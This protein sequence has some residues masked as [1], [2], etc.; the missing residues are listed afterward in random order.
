MDFFDLI[1]QPSAERA[2]ELEAK[3]KKARHD[4][5][6]GT[7]TVSDDVYDAWVA[8]L[9]EVKPD[10]DAVTAVGATPVSEWE[11]VEHS[12][13][14]GS[15]DNV[16]T[17]DELTSWLSGTGE[18]QTAPLM[19]SEKLDGISIAVDYVKGELDKAATRGD[20]N[21]GEDITVNVSKME[22]VRGKLP[23]SFT[24][25][26]RGEIILKRSYHAKYFPEKANPRNAASGIA[27]RYDGQG[28]EH[29]SVK[30]YQV[31]DGQDF[32][33]EA[34]QFKW[35]EDH[36]FDT[37]NWYVT[38]M[39]PGVRTPQDLWLEYQQFKRDELDYDIDGLVVRINNMAAQLALGEKDNCPRGAVAF[40]FAATTRESVLQRIEWQVGGT[41]R[42]TP[43]AIFRPVNI[44]GAEITNAS[45]Y[46]VAYIRSLGLD[47]GATIIVSRAQDVIPRVTEVVKGVGT[48]ANPPSECPACGTL[49][50]AAGEYLICPNA[51]GCPA[52]SVGRI[53]RY[54]AAMDI[55]EWGETLI[56]K[57][58]SSGL[59]KDVSDLYR[60]TDMQLTNVERMGKKSAAKVIKTL[61]VK[62]KVPLE[63][64]LGSLSIPLCASSTIKMA[65]DAGYDT[66]DKLKAASM[67]QLSGVEGLGPVKAQALHTWLQEESEVVDRLLSLG[68]E[69]EAKIQG[70]LTG[71]SF[72]FTGALSKPRPT[73]EKMV[74]DAGGEVKKSVGKRLS[75]LVMADPN[76]NTSKAQ[77]ARKNNTKC[78]SEAEFL[79]ILEG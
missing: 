9:A 26:L 52:Q 56:E 27:R 16:K 23:R 24:G 47:V 37:P 11:K 75:Y 79:A 67:S 18:S 31:A 8:E 35:L 32:E 36:G 21:I 17:I 39:V 51:D 68:V 40:K 20:G 48:I 74:K 5:Y 29:L 25:T 46:N 6:N 77:A 14:M 55:K 60:L 7:P 72:C 12:I 73:F 30:F 42:I 54:V 28:C 78:I 1:S 62:K 57:L 66:F 49:T 22:G 45:L 38:A 53:K 64:L 50:E 43:V 10:S 33:T 15:L 13:P 41:G 70:T 19:T 63:T 65:M 4:Y 34:D 2:S 69:I 3:I 58:V 76:S 44:L 59:V 61:W 71:K